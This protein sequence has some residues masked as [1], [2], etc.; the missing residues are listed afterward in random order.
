MEGLEREGPNDVQEKAGL[1]GCLF[2][3]KRP[4]PEDVLTCWVPEEISREQ[5]VDGFSTTDCAL[6]EEAKSWERPTN[7]TRLG[8]GGEWCLRVQA[9]E[10]E[11]GELWEE[12][13]LAKFSQ[14][15][16]NQDSG[17]VGGYSE[18]PGHWEIFRWRALNAEGA[19]GGILICW[20]KRVLDILDWEEGRVCGRNWGRLEGFGTIPGVL[21]GTSTSLCSNKKGVAKK[22]HLSHEEICRDCGRVRVVDMP[23]QGENSPGMGGSTIRLSR[24]ISD[25]FP[26]VLEGGGIRRGPTPFRFENMWLKVEGFQ[27]VVRAWWQGIDVRGSASY[28]LAI[29]MKEIKK[30]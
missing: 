17:D 27:D 6:Q 11:K 7:R 19:A 29:K 4:T 24:P 23:L 13:S 2:S 10:N 16:G 20:D 18:K 3:R 9:T 14:F 25:H 15:L 5:R 22:N 8:K 28:R 12:C 21:V 30:G 26:I 1:L